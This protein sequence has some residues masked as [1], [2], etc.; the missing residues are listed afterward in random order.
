MLQRKNVSTSM[1]IKNKSEIPATPKTTESELKL[2]QVVSSAGELRDCTRF[3]CNGDVEFRTEGSDV[4]TYAKVTDISL[5]GCYVELTATSAPGTCLNLVVGIRDHRF[6][7]KGVVRTSDP[8]LGMGIAFVEISSTELA[9]LQR[10]LLEL[11]SNLSPTERKGSLVL[12]NRVNT[13]AALQAIAEVFETKSSLTR[14]EF[15]MI[16]NRH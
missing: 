13:M 16:V 15:L 3:K 7:V 6:E 2:A 12:H 10:L 8:C 1:S 4:R 5:A 9:Y 14:D 11:S